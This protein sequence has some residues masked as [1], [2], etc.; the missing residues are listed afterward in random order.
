MLR[1]YWTQFVCFWIFDRSHL[2]LFCRA[3]IHRG[4][5]IDSSSITTA[6]DIA[7]FTQVASFCTVSFNKTGQCA[8]LHVDIHRRVA[9]DDGR[10]TQATA[11]HLTDVC[12]R[13]DV[14]FGRVV[15][16]CFSYISTIF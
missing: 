8:R 7:N 14:Q 3:D 1:L 13:D 4:V 15:G 9:I 12:T 2:Y 11:E 5:A 16:C 6:K 10:L